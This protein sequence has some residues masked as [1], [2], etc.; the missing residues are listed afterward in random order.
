MLILTPGPANGRACDEQTESGD[1][2]TTE[3]ETEVHTARGGWRLERR[4]GKGPHTL[5][6]GTWHPTPPRSQLNPPEGRN[7]G[8]THATLSSPRGTK[9]WDL[10]KPQATVEPNKD[11]RHEVH[12]LH[13]RHC[14]GSPNTPV[15]PRT[16]AVS[17]QP[18]DR[19][20][21]E[22]S[23]APLSPSHVQ[24]RLGHLLKVHRLL[25]S[26][27]LL[28]PA[29][30]RPSGRAEQKGGASPQSSSCPV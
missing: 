1:D 26:Q 5:K 30:T 3:R 25:T 29:R 17:V 19:R 24:R 20:P 12:R 4:P 11:A 18:W 8:R 27:A 16:A 7:G 22:G 13:H 2:A 10:R 6:A 28:D 23:G 14:W 21:R 9:A 15:C